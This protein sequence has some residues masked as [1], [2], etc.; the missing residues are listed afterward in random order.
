MTNTVTTKNVNHIIGV[1]NKRQ[2]SKNGALGHTACNQAGCRLNVVNTNRLSS[3]SQVGAEPREWNIG[4]CKA[5]LQDVQKCLMVDGVERSAQQQ[6]HHH[7]SH[8]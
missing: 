8:G 5:L 1:C 2:W 3:A 6:H 7:Q 4:N